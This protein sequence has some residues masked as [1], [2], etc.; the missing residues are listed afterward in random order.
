MRGAALFAKLH[1]AVGRAKPQARARVHD[2][3]QPIVA[4]KRV[5]PA[6]GLVA[7]EHAQER[8]AALAR[9]HRLDLARERHCLRR[10]PLRQQAG[11]DHQPVAVGYDERP[12]RKPVDE[13]VAIAGAKD[14]VECVAAMR[15]AKTRRN[16]QQ[17]KIVIAED[18]GR[19]IAE[20]DHFA[21]HRERVGP[22]VHEIADE[23]QAVLARRERD[24]VE[25]R[26]ELGVATLEV[27]D[28]V[29]GHVEASRRK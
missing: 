4:G 19:G 8:V 1:R 10:R 5:V 23:P 16:C 28:R 25:H 20:R 29:E 3:A 12:A 27:A 26:A 22:A 24:E 13:C 21:Q 2:R 11:V 18:R 6:P 14:V 9:H 15:P 17:V 7:V